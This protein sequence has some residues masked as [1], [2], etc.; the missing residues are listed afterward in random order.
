MPIQCLSIADYI[1]ERDGVGF[2]DSFNPYRNGYPKL[3]WDYLAGLVLTL[4]WAQHGCLF[5]SCRAGL[6][7]LQSLREHTGSFAQLL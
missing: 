7:E 4:C 2:G 1:C 5:T 6:V 3:L